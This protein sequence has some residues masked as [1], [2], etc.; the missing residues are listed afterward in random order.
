MFKRCVVCKDV[1]IHKIVLEELGHI[2]SQADYHGVESLTEQEQV[3]Y[4]GGCCTAH[5]FMQMD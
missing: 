4:E 2:F 1:V 5:C 3:V